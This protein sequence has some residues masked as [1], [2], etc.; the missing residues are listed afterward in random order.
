MA[1]ALFSAP[2]PT[3]PRGTRYTPQHTPC[4]PPPKPPRCSL[5]RCSPHAHR[6]AGLSATSPTRSSRRVPPTGSPPRGAPARTRRLPARCRAAA[7]NSASAEP[8]ARASARRRS[9][10]PRA[11]ASRRA[12]RRRSRRLRGSTRTAVVRVCTLRGKDPSAL[13]V[14]VGRCRGVCRRLGGLHRS[15]G[16]RAECPG[17]GR[18]WR[19]RF[20]G[21]G[22]AAR[23]GWRL[24]ACEHLVPR[25]FFYVWERQAAENRGRCVF[26]ADEYRRGL[27]MRCPRGIFGTPERHRP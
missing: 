24:V 26:I 13:T 12:R 5:P 22:R 20:G 18:G 27:M 3:P 25:L 7:A 15:R 21:R 19:V 8:T 1:G 11:R 10:A 17:Y 14:V 9:C 23:R 4:S 2:A 16:G 6:A